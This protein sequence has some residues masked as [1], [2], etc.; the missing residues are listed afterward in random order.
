VVVEGP[1]AVRTAVEAGV[2]IEAVFVEPGRHDDLVVDLASRGIDVRP[3][4]VGVLDRVLSTTSPQPVAAVAARPDT[5][6]PISPGD[7][8]FG[9][10]L[11]LAGIGDPG[12]MGTIIR[13]V[14]AAGSGPV[15]VGPGSA[16]PFG[17][18]AVRASVGTVFHATV[19]EVDDLGQALS[20]LRASGHSIL[21]AAPRGGQPHHEADLTGRTVLVLGGETSGLPDAVAGDGLV[22]IAQTGPAESLNVAMAATVLVFEAARQHVHGELS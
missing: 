13:S 21:G 12:N 22:S 17:P 19:H 1:R 8:G 5:A 10:V 2:A 11:V 18:K 16:D 3:V 14:V 9:P 20:G 15:L 7:S 6:G 4:A